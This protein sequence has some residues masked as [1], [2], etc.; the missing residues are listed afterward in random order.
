VDV[1]SGG[2][3]LE[4]K[5][6]QSGVAETAAGLNTLSGAAD[7][8]ETSA[9]RFAASSSGLSK[10][11]QQLVAMLQQ[12]RGEVTQATQLSAA[13]AAQL[14]QELE[15]IAALASATGNLSLVE[16]ELMATSAAVAASQQSVVA[17]TEQAASGFNTSGLA[18]GR[19]RQGFVSLIAQATGTIPVLDRVG[20]TLGTMAL[21]SGVVVGV[22][23]AGAAIALVWQ[24]MTAEA[25]KAAE[26]QQHLAEAL[27]KY[28]NEVQ[29]G[30][31]GARTAQIASIQA[32]IAQKQKDLADLQSKIGPYAMTH[33]EGLSLSEQAAKTYMA[34][35]QRQIAERKQAIATGEADVK[36]IQVR[37]FDDQQS[38]NAA[39]L[40]ARVK[41]N[42][43]DADARAKAIKELKADQAL[44]AQY[45]KLP[46]TTE[47][48]ARVTEYIGLV[49][50]LQDALY[51]KDKVRSPILMPDDPSTKALIASIEKQ[52]EEMRRVNAEGNKAFLIARQQAE[53]VGIQGTA[54]EFLNAKHKAELDM[55]EAYQTLSG[56]ALTQRLADIDAIEAQNRARILATESIRLENDLIKLNAD[57]LKEASKIAISNSHDVIVQLGKEGDAWNKLQQTIN[58]TLANGTVRIVGAR[59]LSQA[60]E[61]LGRTAIRVAEEIQKAWDK[62]AVNQQ[63]LLEDTKKQA[64]SIGAAAVGGLAGFS[65]GQ[66]YGQAGVGYG[67]VSG[68][69][70]GAQIAQAAGLGPGV[71]L[72]GALAGAVGGLL[73]AAQAHREAAK[74]LQD[75]GKAVQVSLAGY[76][77]QTGVAGALAQNAATFQEIK[78]AILGNAQAAARTNNRGAFDTANQQYEQLVKTQAE[79]ATRIARTFWDSIVQALNATAGPAGAYQNSLNE[80]EQQYADN[81]TSAKALGASDAQLA[82]IEQVRVKQEQQLAAAYAE[83]QSQLQ[84]SL[85]ARE[86]YAKG[87]TSEGDAIARRAQEEKELFD[88]QAQGYSD[89]QIA[90]LKYIQGLEDA[91]AAQAKATQAQRTAEDIA[92]RGLRASGYSSQADAMAFQLQ[93]Q[94][95]LEDAIKSGMD[96]NTVALLQSVQALEAVAF[97][98][99]QLQ[100][101]MQQARSDIQRDVSLGFT[102]SA[103]GL[104]QERMAL[105]F[106]GLTNDQIRALYTVFSGTQLTAEQEAM[107]ANIEQFLK[108]AGALTDAAGS[109]A[110]S[111]DT[112]NKASVGTVTA[113]SD[114]QAG[115]ILGRLDTSNTH[116]AAIEDM[117]RNALFNGRGASVFQ[118]AS[119][120][121]AVG[122]NNFF[123]FNLPSGDLDAMAN[124]SP[125]FGNA[126]DRANGRGLQRV[127][128]GVGAT[129]TN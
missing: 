78:D 51:P 54:L 13:R 53:A 61:E 98:A 57:A 84:H 47:N 91:A 70:S 3:T 23:A 32:E 77:A 37:A 128:A 102:T 116:L 22:L 25:R 119:L 67:A 85:D 50:Q 124:A 71:A 100:A 44:V 127:R 87:L 72:I 26:E 106:G 11:Q 9:N 14:Q 16:K 55:L 8:A 104:E 66:Q 17:A 15:K 6:T 76:G 96:P 56:G 73:G 129:R 123:V 45:E 79:N 81:I 36:A 93:Q 60:F 40:A 90:Q 27:I 21:G 5:V 82:L 117:M 33:D 43:A 38:I 48:R 94:R 46:D 35:L 52:L 19:L 92:V 62:L 18:V 31:T 30:A 111:I 114:A 86:A 10:A 105:G 12:T 125:A 69:I 108:D 58:D 20:A 103:A 65:L 28:N 107:N 122:S 1:P 115:G 29:R 59:S 83:V 74:A 4:V 68:G 95:E 112:Y 101:V 42:E 2:A 24:K 99:S 41:Y 39:N 7:K 34:I 113:I 120:G 75:A 63:K 121:G 49:K 109:I 118:A 64:A 89:A 88:A 126:L 97:A 80:I 110:N